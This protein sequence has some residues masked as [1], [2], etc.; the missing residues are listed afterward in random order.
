VGK[1]YIT[2]W[3]DTA[4]GR[5]PKVAAELSRAD[6]WGGLKSAWSIGRMKYM[7]APGLYA[8]GNPDKHSRVFV[9]ANYKLSFDG[10]RRE[11]RGL[12]AWIMVLD[13]KGINVWCAAA[14]II[15]ALRGS[16]PTC[17]CGGNSDGTP[18]TPCC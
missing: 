15:G 3:A 4:A 10:L 8:V 11:L 7:V 2:G 13:T 5:V 16:E 9:T 6:Q 18:K 1:P 12:D 17:D 14:V